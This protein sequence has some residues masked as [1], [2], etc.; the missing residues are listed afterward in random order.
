MLK[1]PKKDPTKSP[2]WRSLAELV[3]WEP[4][5]DNANVAYV[6]LQPRPDFR[7]TYKNHASEKRKCKLLVTH[8]MAG[9]YIEDYFK[10]GYSIQYWQYVD[11]FIY[12]SHHRI[13]V[14][15]RQWT[16]AAHRNG[17]KVLGNFITEDLESFEP[18]FLLLGPG[19]KQTFPELD[20]DQRR[21]FSRF[22][23]NKLIGLA[24]Y[25]NFDGWFFNIES[26]LTGGA[27]QA[28]L[29]VDFLY[30]LREEIQRKKP[31]CLILWY[32]SV[33]K[34]GIRLWQN[35]LNENNFPFFEVTDGMFTNYWWDEQITANSAAAAG[36]HRRRDVYT[37]IDVWG[38]NTYGGGGFDTYKALE[39]I[40]KCRTSAAL[41]APAWTFE[42]LG[43]DNFWINDSLFWIGNS[44]HVLG[45]SK[46]KHGT[47]KAVADYIVPRYTPG[48]ER[49]YTNFSRG[50]GYKFFI[51][52]QQ[53]L[54]Q[55]WYYL[56]LQSIPPLPTLRILSRTA[57]K[58]L[59]KN[60]PITWE[61]TFDVAY[62]G[63]TSIAIHS[64][65]PKR[66]STSVIP[67]YETDIP[68]PEDGISLSATYLPGKNQNVKIGL[69]AHVGLRTMTNEK[70]IV[71]FETIDVDDEDAT[72][73]IVV[74]N[75]DETDEVASLGAGDSNPQGNQIVLSAKEDQTELE[76]GT[77]TTTTT[78]RH[79]WHAAEVMLTPT[80]FD[81]A[82]SV[83]GRDLII[84]RFGV[85]VLHKVNNTAA[86]PAD[87]DLKG[88]PVIIAHVGS[89]S[90][91]PMVE[92]LI[93]EERVRN[94]SANILSPVRDNEYHIVGTIS[95]EIGIHVLSHTYKQTSGLKNTFAYFYVYYHIEA[96]QV[97][98]PAENELV[99]L[100]CADTR[101]F[102][103]GDLSLAVDKVQSGGGGIAF[104]VR[105][106]YENGKVDVW[107][108]YWRRL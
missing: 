26:H 31:G 77:L 43:A 66:S 16:N 76:F 103:V 44:K 68:I 39:V 65:K 38:R 75:G 5:R 56:S 24:E 51:D 45:P 48:T 2:F 21:V 63:G 78:K 95:W 90:I 86:E 74:N 15:P 105:G 54:D 19:D 108:R 64:T 83:K 23:A 87:E 67:L 82:E 46:E 17:V 102:W 81:L 52:G 25:Y 29:F 80:M 57:T 91:N 8:D 93:S 12:F 62:S 92:P 50:C 10:I 32:D 106:V 70:K 100:G 69:Y 55:E 98:I 37:G 33:T 13:S 35:Q 99:F 41:F 58:T 79:N 96:G 101:E 11:I 94:L 89:L 28:S 61:Y 107:N 60:S 18:D 88:Q 34:D 42:H 4:G 84:K 104:W 6:N 7:P 30:C 36:K 40:Q 53:V 14:P 72:S 59:R 9:G 3:A 49:F 27:M 22:F 47:Q 71:S 20:E 73:F 85:T 1:L 97:T